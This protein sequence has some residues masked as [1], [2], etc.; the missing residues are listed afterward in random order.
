MASV[1]NLATSLLIGVK[2]FLLTK[3]IAKIE[4]AKKKLESSKV[5]LADNRKKADTE[6]EDAYKK[7]EDARK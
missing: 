7:I 3:L 6:F 1:A 5:E 4:N 2:L